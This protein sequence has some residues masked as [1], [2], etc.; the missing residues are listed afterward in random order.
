MLGVNAELLTTAQQYKAEFLSRMFGITAQSISQESEIR[1]LRIPAESNIVGV[2]YGLREATSLL[3][4]N[5][6][7]LRVYVREKLPKLSLPASEKIPGSVNGISTDVIPVGDI[8]AH[9]RPTKCGVSIGHYMTQ[10]GTLGCLVKQIGAEAHGYYILSNNHVLAN[11]NRAAIGDLILHPGLADGGDS[12]NPIAKLTDF[13]RIHHAEDDHAEEDNLM[14]A[15]IAR[16]LNHDEV[17]P[18]IF[19][20]GKLQPPPLAAY[21]NQRVCKYGRTSQYTLGTVGDI[22][23][24]IYV[25]YDG[26]RA[27]FVE[28]IAIDW[29]DEQPFSKPGD[30]GAIV[31]DC[32]TKQPVALLFSAGRRR[33][34][35][36]TRIE[37]VLARFNA[38]IL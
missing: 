32:N 22:S 18:T 12:I 3:E 26:I 38:E 6:P 11:W 4:Q 30:S 20:I 33:V 37:L 9:S 16:V 5:T 7:A 24:D 14:D 35:Y 23:A 21:R 25:N 8:L 31:V 2:G 28:Q 10:G 15:A 34:S 1:T 17:I 36:A 29:L 19:D 13:E 27:Y